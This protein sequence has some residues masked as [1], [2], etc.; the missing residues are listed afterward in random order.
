MYVASQPP[1]TTPSKAYTLLKHSETIIGSENEPKALR[2]Q[3]SRWRTR[4]EADVTKRRALAGPGGTELQTCAEALHA[5]IQV[6]LGSSRSVTWLLPCR[7][8]LGCTRH[9]TSRRIGDFENFCQPRS[10]SEHG[11]PLVGGSRKPMYSGWLSKPRDLH[12]FRAQLR[13]SILGLGDSSALGGEGWEG[14]SRLQRFLQV[15]ESRGPNHGS[16]EGPAKKG[17]GS[18]A[19]NTLKLRI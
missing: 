6:P 16:R 18:K 17:P 15:L 2:R 1:C 12:G 8:I 11:R 14:A 4:P 3:T 5:Q 19:L 10:A 7:E 13:N 9:C